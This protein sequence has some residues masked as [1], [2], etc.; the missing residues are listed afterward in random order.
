MDTVTVVVG[1][2]MVSSSRKRMQHENFQRFKDPLATSSQHFYCKYVCL[3][4]HFN[5]PHFALGP[6]IRF[7]FKVEGH[8]KELI[9]S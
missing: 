4:L 2:M 8:G 3:E 7:N 1:A 6:Y 5:I 9:L